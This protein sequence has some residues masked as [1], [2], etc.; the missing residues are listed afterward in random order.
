MKSVSVNKFSS[1]LAHSALLLVAAWFTMQPAVAQYAEPAHGRAWTVNGDTGIESRYFFSDPRWPGQSGDTASSWSTNLEFRW[2]N[3]DGDQRASIQPFLRLDS[4]DSERNQFDLREAYWALEGDNWELLLGLDKVFWGVAESRHLVDIVN[5]TALV[6]DIDQEQK[7][8]QPMIR[9]L[10]MSDW[11]QFELFVMPWFRERTFP[12]LD[13]RLRPPLPVDQDGAVY[14]SSAKQHH[15]DVALRWSHYFGD[16]D[17]GVSVFHGTSREPKLIPASDGA[18]LLPFYHQ[19]SQ[20]GVDMQYTRNAW[21]WKL[22]TIVRDGLDDSF[23]ASVAGFEYTFFGV[24]D[25]AIDVGLLFEYLYDGRDA[26]ESATAF[27]DDLFF[28]ARLG[29][30]DTQDTSILA[31]VVI[32]RRDSDWFFSLEA[33]RR[34]GTNYSIEARL[35]FFHGESP[36]GQ[37]LP[38]DRDDYLQISLAR[39]F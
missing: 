33:E 35:R 29:F 30:N 28:G 2:R 38:L 5:Q 1:I 26:S 3:L 22:E 37:L 14:E 24:R 9:T 31:G 34:L 19:I 20:L 25:S 6:E 39:Y 17:I 4:I 23:F 21:L 12:G 18:S 27:D 11:G 10:Y 36:N 32:D 8:G 16:V 7:L 15:T 13:G